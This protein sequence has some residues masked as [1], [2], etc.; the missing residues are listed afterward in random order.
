[1]KNKKILYF[2][3]IFAI[4]VRKGFKVHY[5]YPNFKTLGNPVNTG[6]LKVFSFCLVTYVLLTDKN[7]HAVRKLGNGCF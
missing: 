2:A 3:C 1:M 5:K 4:I 7:S 6:H